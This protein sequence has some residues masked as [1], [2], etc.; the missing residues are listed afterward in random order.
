MLALKIISINQKQWE[1][2]SKRSGTI[3]YQQC[4]MERKITNNINNQEKIVSTR[5]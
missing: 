1:I 3:K 2:T 4:T 5:P